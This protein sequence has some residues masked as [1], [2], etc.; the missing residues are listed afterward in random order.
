MVA[1][2]GSDPERLAWPTSRSQCC[3][4]LARMRRQC[5]LPPVKPAAWRWWIIAVFE[6]ASALRNAVLD[7]SGYFGGHFGVRTNV[8]S[9]ERVVSALESIGTRI[10]LIL[11]SGESDGD[12]CAG[13]SA[14]IEDLRRFGNRIFREVISQEEALEAVKAGVD[15]LVAK[16]NEA[17][18]RV[19]SETSF[20]LLQRLCSTVT[21][22]V[23]AYG[24]IGPHGAAACRVA[25]AAGIV[26]QDEIALAEECS[27][28][29]PLRSRIAA[30]DGTETIC[31]GE[32]LGRRYRVHR[33][34]GASLIRELQQL[35]MSGVEPRAFAGAAG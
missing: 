21:V 26:L 3:L 17:A 14:S 16:G 28:P 1:H 33:Q 13:L 31:L 27:I 20:V 5:W 10:D 19:G 24:G 9:L 25:G 12:G 11:L 6:D 29:E 4:L 2:M 23:W 22:P 8:R 15:G 7:L 30:M 35:E 32:S 34:E 18:G